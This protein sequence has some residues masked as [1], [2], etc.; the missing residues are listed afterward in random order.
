MTTTHPPPDGGEPVAVPQLGHGDTIHI[1]PHD[2]FRHTQFVH[3][4]ACRERDVEVDCLLVVE[5]V[6]VICWGICPADDD[7]RVFGATVYDADD[8]VIRL[9][10][11][12][13]A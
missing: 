7:P 10:A 3:L 6:I 9:E 4:V 13:A 5:S 11:A 12:V 8:S 1:S 2:V